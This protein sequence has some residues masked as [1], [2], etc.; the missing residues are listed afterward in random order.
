MADFLFISLRFGEHSREIAQ[1]ELGDL[2]RSTV[3]SAHEVD[4]L[5]IDSTNVCIPHL[6]SYVGVIVGGSALNV[7][8]ST[9]DEF[10]THVHSE[11]TRL[12]GLD[13]PVF[14]ICFGMGF[15]AQA[16]GGKVDRSRPEVTGITEVV[17]SDVPDPL[18]ASLPERFLALT[19]H[20]ESTVELGDGAIILAQG[21]TCFAQMV[22]YRDHVWATQFHPEMDADAMKVRM[23]FFMNHGYFSPEDYDEIV[24]NI[25]DFD[26][27][28]AH[29][30]I[31]NFVH[32]CRAM[33]AK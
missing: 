15:L 8:T 33:A 31:N 17:L 11:L 18:I 23:A 7:T 14:L 26:V 1:A 10:Q 21:P 20:Q 13:I 4:H 16:T 9:Y 28:Y 6:D 32:H 27:S 25:R 22:R 30:V 5:I 19:G 3:L 24:S 29:A 2:L 12:I